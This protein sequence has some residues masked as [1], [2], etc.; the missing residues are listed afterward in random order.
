MS[1]P[2]QTQS[3]RRNSM[4]L[5]LDDIMQ[6]KAQ[7]VIEGAADLTREKG[8]NLICAVAS[9]VHDRCPLRDLINPA[10]SDGVLIIS[11]ILSNFERSQERIL[12]FFDR[13]RPMPLVNLGDPFEK[14]HSVTVNNRAGMRDVISHLI[15]VHHFHKI[16]FIRGPETNLEAEMRFKVYQEMLEQ[17]GIAFDPELVADGNWRHS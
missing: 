8:S 11:S 15:K 13:Y 1:D 17:H 5:L 14:V 2:A 12:Q 10:N 9:S 4:T 3:Q 7:H 6:P 16:A